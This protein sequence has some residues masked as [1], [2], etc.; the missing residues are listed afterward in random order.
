MSE[1][2]KK[3]KKRRCPECGSKHLIQDYERGE[4]ICEECGLVIDKQYIDE[5]PEWRSF[6]TEQKNNRARTGPPRTQLIHDRGLSTSIDSS[7]KDSYGRS[8]SGKKRGQVYRLRKWQRRMRVS[9]A[10]ERN[11]S[12]AFRE[13]SR[14]ASALGIPK[15]IRE[16]AA[17]IY[18]KAVEKNLIRG[19]SIDCVVAST[20]Y[21]ACRRI[22]VPR[23]LDEIAN[24]SKC[25]RKNL[26][27]TY[28]FLSRELGL[29]I[30]PTKPQEYLSR[31]CSEL[32]LNSRSQNMA[33]Q[34]INKAQEKGLTSGK[35]PTGIAAATIYIASIKNN[36]RRTQS[37]IADVAGVTEVTVRNRY[38]E[39]VKKL[40]IDLEV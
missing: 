38:K 36:Q 5:G 7:N 11:L 12:H 39:L 23:T 20:L 29:K 8:F 31:F 24:I 35:G 22:S 9:S 3:N 37:A 15:N 19:R 10:K 30:K 33:K 21:A 2:N 26:G 17:V 1:K 13:L 32:G 14:I 40:N 25:D 34:I 27:R 28:R 18:R 4:L 6:N 16:N